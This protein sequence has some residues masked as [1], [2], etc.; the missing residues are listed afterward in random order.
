MTNIDFTKISKRQFISVA[1]FAVL[2]IAAQT[3]LMRYVR[4]LSEEVSSMRSETAL[5]E[6]IFESKSESLMYYKS[7]VNFNGMKLPA[8][9]VS[10]TQ[11]YSFLITKLDSVGMSDAELI[12]GDDEGN[13]VSFNISG[14]NDY[15]TLMRLLLSFRESNLLL[16]V[17]NLNISSPTTGGVD[18]MFVV[19]AKL[20][21]AP[22]SGEAAK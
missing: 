5:Q 9:A 8:E 22:P 7:N 12:K 13:L 6:R 19:Q 18:F 20:N 14:T 4:L 10:P 3:A 2:L 17:S 1:L 11:V 15:F 21:P 16:R